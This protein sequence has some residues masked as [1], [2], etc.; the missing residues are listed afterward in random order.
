MSE[1]RGL[2]DLVERL[3]RLGD[4][5]DVD[6]AQLVDAVL[7]RIDSAPA[8]S[9]PRRW[10]VAAAVVALAAG[11][12]LHPDSRDAMA[13]WLGLDG[14]TVEIDPEL[15][16]PTS[17][18]SFDAPGPGESEVVIVDGREVLVSAL[19]GRLDERLITKTVSSSD[20]VE[21]VEVSGHPGLW[22][23]GTAHEVMYE[24]PEGDVVVRRVAANTL[25]WQDGTVLYRV[26]GFAELAD[27]LAFAEGT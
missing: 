17:S 23:S 15:S 24:S 7:D 2:P 27:A 4:A 13:R 6:D 16:V 5:L 14:V 25:L 10:L 9:L 20:Q 8:R 22:V 19:D 21:Q 3:A 12:V 18:A 1:V 26:E 11:I